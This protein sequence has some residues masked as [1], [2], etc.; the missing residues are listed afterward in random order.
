MASRAGSF[1]AL[2]Q[3]DAAVDRLDNVVEYVHLFADEMRGGVVTVIDKMHEERLRDATANVLRAV[4]IL[5]D[6]R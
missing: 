4:Q 6:L 3:L 5:G 2:A 1:D